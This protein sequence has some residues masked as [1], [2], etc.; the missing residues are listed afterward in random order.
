MIRASSPQSP[1][2]AGIAG[3]LTPLIDVLFMLIVFMVL[4]A[5]VADRELDADFATT[6]EAELA[7]GKS[8]DSLAVDVLAG[9]SAAF[10]IDGTEYSAWR[11]AKAALAARLGRSEAPRVRIAAQ[12]DASSQR[13]LDVLSFLQSRGIADVAVVMRPR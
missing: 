13:L 12:A 4:T 9:A 1:E 2:G 10:R 11:D 6:E 8:P 3:D 7:P 5:N